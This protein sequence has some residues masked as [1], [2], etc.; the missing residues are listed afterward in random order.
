VR[1]RAPPTFLHALKQL[2]C[3][4]SEMAVSSSS[5]ALVTRNPG[6]SW[7]L[8]GANAAK[9]SHR[10][11]INNFT[12]L[13][14]TNRTIKSQRFT[15]GGPAE[16][17][18]EMQTRYPVNHGGS[19]G[20][21][22]YVYLEL[23]LDTPADTPIT[24]QAKIFILNATGQRCKEQTFYV[25]DTHEKKRVLS[26]N[27]TEH[28]E[29]VKI[30]SELL[31]DDSLTILCELCILRSPIDA[32]IMSPPITQ[33][34][35]TLIADLS[36]LLKE[37][38]YSDFKLKVDGKEFEVH[39]SIL[40]ARSPVFKAMFQHKMRESKEKKVDISDL[41]ADTVRQMLQHIYTGEVST[42]E[43]SAESLLEAA[44]KYDL[45]SLKSACEETLRSKLEVKNAAR[46]LMLADKHHADQL[47][48]DCM[49]FFAAHSKE[50]Q[51]SEGWDAIKEQQ[52]SVSLKQLTD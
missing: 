43:Q 13:S 16:W 27:F 41:S 25:N 18:L 17:H 33:P 3:E 15:G 32:T 31:V 45:A 22:Y 1:V 21:R 9:V 29:V 28:N 30:K 35:S 52:V 39:M 5:A 38:L 50:V 6:E 47:K 10:W 20:Y 14:N 36:S 40:S 46:L 51:E 4:L 44:D 34:P 8:T 37:G 49:H 12:V 19:V 26:V 48:A 42:L 11:T 2:F 7:S 24:A 23:Y